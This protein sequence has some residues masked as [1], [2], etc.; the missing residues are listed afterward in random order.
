MNIGDRLDFMA[1]SVVTTFQTVPFQYWRDAKCEFLKIA[2]R[3][4]SGRWVEFHFQSY[5]RQMACQKVSWPSGPLGDEQ[6]A[7]VLSSGQ[8]SQWWRGG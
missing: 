6:V 2:S 7:I 5:D 4:A 1:T 8:E 3:V